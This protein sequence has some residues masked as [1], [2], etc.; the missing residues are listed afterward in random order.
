[1]RALVSIF[2]D[3]AAVEEY[4]QSKESSS[5][6]WSSIVT[7]PFLTWVGHPSSLILTSLYLPNGWLTVSR[8]SRYLLVNIQG[9]SNGL[10]GFDL[11]HHTATLY[12]VSSPA[13]MNTTTFP[14]IGRSVVSLLLHPE[15]T[16]NRR[17]YVHS[18]LLTGR[19]LLE[20]LQAVS[21]PEKK[22]TVQEASTLDAER[23]GKALMEKGEFF[24]G[25]F[26]LLKVPMWRAG[27]GGDYSRLGKDDNELLGLEQENLDAVL[28]EVYAQ[29]QKA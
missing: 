14:Q 13:L 4:L 5:F 19:Q 20:R 7:G 28:A 29:A 8:L 26:N 9:L 6:T 16:R 25:L 17:V 3:K 15:P 11:K 23:E 10:L 2:Q 22:W 21:G 27:T 1:M 18:F 24:P 12:D